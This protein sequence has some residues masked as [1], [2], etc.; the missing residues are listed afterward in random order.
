M[1][2]K[3]K[4][5]DLNLI[6]TYLEVLRDRSKEEIKTPKLNNLIIKLNDIYFNKSNLKKLKG[7]L[8]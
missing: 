6:I 5:T 8:K 4:D 2:H 3:I 7:G 1:I